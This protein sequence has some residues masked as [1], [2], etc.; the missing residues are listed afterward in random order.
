MAQIT[1]EQFP[2][3][4]AIV[5]VTAIDNSADAISCNYDDITF[6]NVSGNIWINPLITAVA[7]ATA[8][9]L[10]VGQSIDLKVATTLSIISDG[11]GGTYQY[12]KWAKMC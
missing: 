8:I 1:Q 5:G 11:S 4:K 2:L 7:D 3:A 12:I 9:K 10:T 6:I